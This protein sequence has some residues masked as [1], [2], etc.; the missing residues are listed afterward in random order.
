MSDVEREGRRTSDGPAGM[1]SGPGQAE[2]SPGSGEP[3]TVLHGLLETLY[4]LHLPIVGVT[5]V[6]D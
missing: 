1:G 2:S 3:R 6:D 5:K 4:A